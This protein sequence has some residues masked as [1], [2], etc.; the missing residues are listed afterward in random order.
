MYN[1]M[2]D[3]HFMIAVILIFEGQKSPYLDEKVGR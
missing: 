2:I 1:K 3:F